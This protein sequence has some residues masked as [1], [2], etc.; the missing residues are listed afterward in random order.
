METFTNDGLRFEVSDDGPADGPLVILLHGFP[1]DRLSW[2]GVTPTL[3]AAGCRTLAPDQRG[4]APGARPRDHREYTVEKLAGDVLA[5]ADEVGA[6][7]FDLVGHDWGGALAWYVAAY[8]PDRVRSLTALS[9]PH[10]GAVQQAFTRSTQ[11]LHLLYIPFFRLP[12]IPER[13]MGLGHGKLMR[14]GLLRT[15]LDGEHAERF[16]RR[17]IQRDDLTGPLNW[18]RAL[19][20]G[21]GLRLPPVKVP[22][23]F[24]WSDRDRFVTRAAAERCGQWV[25]G[26]Y[27]Y[28][29]LTG[30]SHWIPEEAPARTGRLILD[31]VRAAAD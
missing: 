23:L 9:V 6:Q 16:A 5:L 13:V 21:G 25:T 28:H 31:Q 8:H 30:V 20:A 22:T 17:A 4:Y 18:Y 11:A 14:R 10:A 24:V 29:V 3:A 1:E 7:R 27:R 26:P 19:P 15:G 12:W 2:S